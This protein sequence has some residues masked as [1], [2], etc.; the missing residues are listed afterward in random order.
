MRADVRR[1]LEA[2]ERALAPPWE[3]LDPVTRRAEA[4]RALD[5]A[6]AEERAALTAEVGVGAP[7]QD[8][9]GGDC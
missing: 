3:A 2:L 5:E 7:D 8:G 1:R 4:M 6:E 9:D